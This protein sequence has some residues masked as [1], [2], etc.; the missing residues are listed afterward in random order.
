MLCP[1]GGCVPRGG[2]SKHCMVPSH[3]SDD[4]GGRWG[5][6]CP[7]GRGSARSL[8][9]GEASSPRG[10][11]PE[12]FAGHQ[13]GSQGD[14][15]WGTCHAKQRGGSCR[16]LQGQRGPG[17]APSLRT[18]GWHHAAP[19]AQGRALLA[20]LPQTRELCSPQTPLAAV[21]PE[22]PAPSLGSPPL[23][24]GNVPPFPPQGEFKQTSSFLV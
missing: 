5:P 24:P 21:L 6:R 9:R 7:P 15:S 8:S 12:G 17:G 16:P 19:P 4:E 11:A 2:P 22:P 10:S 20:S 3:G 1:G 18:T 13:K 23:P 14:G